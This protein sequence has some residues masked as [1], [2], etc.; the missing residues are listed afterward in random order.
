MRVRLP[1]S[2]GRACADGAGSVRLPCNILAAR[3]RDGLGRRRGGSG[4]GK[5]AAEAVPTGPAEAHGGSAALGSL[6][7]AAVP[8]VRWVPVGGRTAEGRMS[9]AGLKKQFY[10]AS[11]V[12]AGHS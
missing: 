4:A 12:S 10:K 6:S 7:L 3:A 5:R 1:D 8:P 9:V 2:R 11:Q